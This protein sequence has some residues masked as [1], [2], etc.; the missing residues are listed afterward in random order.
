MLNKQTFET[1][2]VPTLT[3]RRAKGHCFTDT[4]ARNFVTQSFAL[5][6][7][8]SS[9]SQLYEM[10]LESVGNFCHSELRMFNSL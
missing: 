2:L 8:M 1:N 3:K 7:A 5:L 6:V 9:V 4:E 10:R